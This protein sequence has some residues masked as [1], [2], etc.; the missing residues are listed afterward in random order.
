MSNEDI[1]TAEGVH[2]KVYPLIKG[3][4]TVL[5]VGCGTG[6]FSVKGSLYGH[7]MEACGLEDCKFSDVIPF[8]QVDF[9]DNLLPYANESFDAAVAIEVIE[10]VNDPH[11]FIN[12]LYRVV[13]K[14]GVVVLT[15]PN[16]ENWYNRL[17]YL[18]TGKLLGFSPVK[19]KPGEPE[20]NHISPIFMQIYKPY[21][22][23]LFTIEEVT[24]NRS[25]IPLLRIKLP[26]KH[27]LFSDTMILKLRKKC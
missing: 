27:K 2:N 26:T 12:E 19:I 6:A 25:F 1:M 10:H 3:C 13:K 23:K 14:D 17:Y 16:V 8:K 15:T 4:D 21:I 24:T 18:C 22:E 9:N 5:D 7:Y 20:N 11:R